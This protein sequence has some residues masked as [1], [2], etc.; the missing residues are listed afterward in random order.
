M[1]RPQVYSSM[2]S[3]SLQHRP[4]PVAADLGHVAKVP[5]A[6]DERDG[7]EV[8]LALHLR[9]ERKGWLGDAHD[10]LDERLQHLVLA[11]LFRENVQLA[12]VLLL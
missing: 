2:H 1:I 7:E 3:P 9:G 6:A 12:L 4:R 11:H 8:A 10:A 5:P